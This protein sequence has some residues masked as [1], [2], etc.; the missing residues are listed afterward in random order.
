MASI[1]GS[2]SKSFRWFSEYDAADDMVSERHCRMPLCD[3]VVIS[4][5]GSPC[6][7]HAGFYETV[8]D[9]FQNLKQNM[10]VASAILREG[11]MFKVVASRSQAHIFIIFTRSTA[12]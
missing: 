7:L 12:H 9:A 11:Y 2:G 5:G 6:S 10:V 3:L 4:H 8:G 1:K